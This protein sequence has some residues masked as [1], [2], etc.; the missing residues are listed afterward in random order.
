M[1]E[2][3]R[4]QLRAQIAS[5]TSRGE[6]KRLGRWLDQ[7]SDTVRRAVVDLANERGAEL[8]EEAI[9][10][11]GKRLVRWARARQESARER[12][13]PIRLDES[14]ICLVCGVDVPLGGARVRDHC[15]FCLHSLHVDRVPGDRASD[16]LGHL[17]PAALTQ[18]GG[19]PVIQFVCERC[20]HR[21]RCRAHTDDSQEALR[22]LSGLSDP[23]TLRRLR[24]IALPQ[25]VKAFLEREQLIEGRLA[26]GVSG[27]VDSM[28]L[29]H[30]LVELGH[31]PLVLSVDHGIR[32]E[33][34][35]E[36]E[37]V[38]EKARSLGLEFLGEHLS[39]EPG[40]DLAQ[41]ARDLRHAFFDRVPA[42][43]VALGHHFDDQAETV[44]DRLMRGAGSGGLAGM[45]PRRARI[46]RPL[47]QESRTQ[48]EDWA[49]LKGLS[50][51]EDPSN[52]KGMRGRIRNE[53]LPLMKDLR[54]GASKAIVR[55]AQH[56][57]EDDAVLCEQAE[58]LLKTEG[59]PLESWESAAP[60]LQRRAVLSLV[61]RE[62]GAV[63]DLSAAQLTQVLTLSQPGSWVGIA[64]GWRIVRD[65][66]ELRCLPPV[67][68]P[69]EIRQGMWGLWKI[70][71]TTTVLVRSIRQG[72]TGDGT[73]LRERLRAAGIS[74]ALR[75][76]H[77]LIE[78]QG[79]RWLPGVWLE[80]REEPVGVVVQ[81]ERPPRPSLPAGGPYSTAL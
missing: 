80:K 60:P 67:P 51:V 25:R 30:V 71:S 70:E 39:L 19:E 69:Q 36:L 48:I 46:V 33:S 31:K 49:A 44:L 55:S 56:L 28:V 40:P 8:P 43:T 10:W 4:N 75:S 32:P 1:S 52:S 78:I 35:H 68:V 61:R 64:E 54:Q 24:A 18:V 3:D 7:Q 81:C 65:V 76:L 50:F 5:A 20:G 41:R 29:L 12:K 11:P 79:R 9:S 13:N 42:D 14:F 6:Q 16:C 53:L 77:P 23:E 34:I 15:P 22:A 38:Q 26:V 74:V 37:M 63:T 27:G 59:L 73:S 47:L 2:V 57:A 66:S 72:E 21:H 45:A 17:V 62:K 58:A